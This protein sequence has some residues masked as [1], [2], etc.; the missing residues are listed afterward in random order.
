MAQRRRSAAPAT[1]RAEEDNEELCCQCTDCARN[2]IRALLRGGAKSIFASGQP[3]RRYS[4]KL[5]WADRQRWV[6][7]AGFNRFPP[8]RLE[9][10]AVDLPDSGPQ[11][12]AD[13]VFI[14][15]SLTVLRA[16]RR[17]KR[18]RIG[19]IIITP[20]GATLSGNRGMSR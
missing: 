5:L 17:E 7:A 6:H 8:A 2:R 12:V 13:Q 3:R 20:P 10:F 11:W 19:S 9:Q 4:F 1:L 15:F 18:N 16:A 14:K